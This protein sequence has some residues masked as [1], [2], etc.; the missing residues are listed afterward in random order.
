[1]DY[2]DYNKYSD[3]TYC[4]IYHKLLCVKVLKG[5]SPP[6]QCHGQRYVQEPHI[7]YIVCVTF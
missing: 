5:L 6:H 2:F 1:M 7:Q 4:A 3:E